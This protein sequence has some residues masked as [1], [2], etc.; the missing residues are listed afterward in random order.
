MTILKD[1]DRKRRNYLM[2]QLR[3]QKEP[4]ATTLDTSDSAIF[5]ALEEARNILQ[6]D[7]GNLTGLERSRAD[8]DVELARWALA[9][10]NQ[11]TDPGSTNAQLVTAE[12]QS[13]DPPSSEPRIDP[14]SA[15]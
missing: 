7:Y 5:F 14:E 9:A 8:K 6:E 13:I 15:N 11:I 4:G 10:T 3:K 12:P 1:T 2:L